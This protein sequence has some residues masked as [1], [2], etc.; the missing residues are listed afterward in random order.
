ML[1]RGLAR[2]GDP[3]IVRRPIFTTSG[4]RHIGT[5]VRFAGGLIAWWRSQPM[6][7]RP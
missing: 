4:E 1:T 7:A 2:E 3:S 5:N 6:T